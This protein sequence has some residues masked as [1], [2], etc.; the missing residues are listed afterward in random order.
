MSSPFFSFTE[1]GDFLKAI[2]TVVDEIELERIHALIDGGNLPIT[3]KE[4]LATMLGV[5]PG[6]VWSLINRP[7]RH[8]RRFSIP[9]GKE[10]REI[11]APKIGLKIVQK[12]ISIQLQSS[13][14]FPDHVFGFVSGYSHIDA[15]SQHTKSKWIYSID[16]ENFFPSTPQSWVGASL[17]ISGYDPDSA[18]LI[19][20]L[21]C[22]GGALAQ[23]APS[24]PVLSNITMSGVDSS[25][26]AFAAELGIR[27]T[28]YADDI[29]FSSTDQFPEVLPER[30]SAL[31]A[32]TPWN[33][34]TKKTHLAKAP[35]RLKV[36]GLH[37]PHTQSD[38]FWSE[39]WREEERSEEEDS[40]FASNIVLFDP[41]HAKPV[42]SALFRI[43]WKRPTAQED[44]NGYWE[45]K[46]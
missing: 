34:S 7:G 23:G 15:A 14:S 1:K 13:A 44:G 43:D 11:L 42:R 37:R 35:A 24:S 18:S 36:H 8:Y 31:F 39:G 26:S 32:N 17:G 33:I 29:T 20:S 45:A 46:S 10:Q 22:F 40:I 41:K 16:L 6:I 38:P 2:K 3:S 5:N 28:R 21:C 12:W 9:K 19:A 27:V 25:L 4:V 30:L